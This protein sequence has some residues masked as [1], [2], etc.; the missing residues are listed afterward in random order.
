MKRSL[1]LLLGVVSLAASALNEIDATKVSCA[2]FTELGSN[3]QKRILAFL[4]GYAHRELAEDQVGSVPIG[5]GLPRVLDAC[6][7]EPTAVVWAKV[8]E[9]APGRNTGDRREAGV[10]RPPTEITCASYLKLDRYDRRLTVY[11]LDGYSRKPDPTDANQS[12]VALQRNGEDWAASACKKRKQR[13]WWAIQGG[14]RSVA[15]APAS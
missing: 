2:Q 5:A 15:P 3:R 4:Q 8:Q 1:L 11:W 7:H 10:T 13:L 12:V 6:A 9:L 14:V